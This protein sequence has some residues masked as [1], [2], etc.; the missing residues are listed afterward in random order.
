M[1]WLIVALTVLLVWRWPRRARAHHSQDRAA[2]V[3][4]PL[5]AQL[6]RMGARLDA[7]LSPGVLPTASG[8]SAELARTCLEVSRLT[9]CPLRE[10]IEIAVAGLQAEEELAAARDVAVAGPRLTS[11]VLAALPLAGI[12][13]GVMLGADP[14]GAMTDGGVGTIAAGLAGLLVLIGVRWSRRMIRQVVPT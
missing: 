2:P 7:G 14:I 1:S 5:S 3:Q 12:G 4:V 8:E 11:W 6:A 10:A 9:G 13:L